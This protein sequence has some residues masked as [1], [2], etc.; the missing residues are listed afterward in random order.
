MMP[1]GDGLDSFVLQMQRT[2]GWVSDA[3]TYITA[4]KYTEA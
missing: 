1:A 4:A 3:F 2:L